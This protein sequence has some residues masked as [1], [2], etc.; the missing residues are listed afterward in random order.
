M[1][2]HE[3]DLG[4]A[5]GVSRPAVRT[6]GV[7][8]LGSGWPTTREAEHE[9]VDLVAALDDDGVT[10]CT[11]FVDGV[12]AVT[13]G[14]PDLPADEPGPSGPAADH[15]AGRAGRAFVFP[16]SATLRAPL[17]VAELLART[18]V[19]E[20]RTL[21]GGDR[22]DGESVLDPRGFVRPHLV[23]GR[24]VLTVR[25]ALGGVLVPFEQREQIACCSDH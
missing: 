15:A 9:T 10:A 14:S 22:A 17:S 5:A 6:L 21:G 7:R 20:V 19:A 13:V 16:G 25:P 12:V 4:A 1:V 11:H 23:A 8:L 3:P 2:L 24:L 18:A